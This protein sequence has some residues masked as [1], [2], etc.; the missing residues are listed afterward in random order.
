M[1]KVN[2]RKELTSLKEHWSQKIIGQ[3][4]GRLIKIA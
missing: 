2:I 3:A 1:E 4:N